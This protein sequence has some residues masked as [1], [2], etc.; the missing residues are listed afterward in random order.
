MTAQL[1][2]RLRALAE[3]GIRRALHPVEW[4]RALAIALLPLRLRLFLLGLVR[5]RAD[6]PVPLRDL[7]VRCSEWRQ[8]L[9]ELIDEG[10]APAAAPGI[11][12]PGED[13]PTTSGHR[14]VSIVIPIYGEEAV[15]LLCLESLFAFTGY[16]HFEVILVDNGSPSDCRASLRAF[17][18]RRGVRILLNERNRGFAAACNQGVQHSRGE[19]LCFLNNDTVVTPGWLTRLVEAVL[20]DPG[21][22]MVGPVTNA[23][24][25]EARLRTTYSAL[26]GMLE[27]AG[28]RA[29]SRQGQSFSIPMVAL[30][31]AVMR[32]SVWDEVGCLDERYGLG[33]FEDT[34]YARQ[35]RSAGYDLRCCEDV[36][37]H[38]WHQ[39]SFRKLER[40]A[41]VRLYEQ[42][43]AYYRSK[44]RALGRGR[45]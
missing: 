26:T 28:E 7:A 44:W 40:E 2:R 14:L 30:F 39:A 6:D 5:R 21:L 13:E 20:E 15:T 32:R 1:P 23:T 37:I 4:A 25:N 31:C 19:L 27:F 3:R 17:A 43:R 18:A 11:P 22:G 12:P 36:F 38:H 16:P 42:N 9:T 34:D 45:A 8:A 35:L 33:L 29:R 24:G 10:T 41:Y